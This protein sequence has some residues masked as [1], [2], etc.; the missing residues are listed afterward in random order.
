[1]ALAPRASDLALGS[2]TPSRSNGCQG[3]STTDS[4][5]PTVISSSMAPLRSV[6]VS[7]AKKHQQATNARLEVPPRSGPSVRSCLAYRM[8]SHFHN[9]SPRS[10]PRSLPGHGPKPRMQAS[11]T[12]CGGSYHKDEHNTH[13]VPPNVSYQNLRQIIHRTLSCRCMCIPASLYRA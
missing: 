4:C 11:F 9:G 2:R 13:R 6:A 12:F 7:E 3:Q 10:P 5:E 8:K 1:M